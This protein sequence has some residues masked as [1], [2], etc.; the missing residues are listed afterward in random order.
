MA[1]DK[2]I[3]C[4]LQLFRQYGYEGTTLSKIAEAT[5]LG[6]ASLYHHFPGGKDEMV[7]AVLD[8]LEGWLQEH[9][10][11]ELRSQGDALT[12]LQ[13]MSASMSFLYEQGRQPCLFAILL[14]G[15]AKDIFQDRVRAILN[16]WIKEMA[17]VLVEAGLD[18]TE[19]REKAEDAAIA[20]QG[21]LILAQGLDDLTIFHR[22]LERLPQQMCPVV[23]M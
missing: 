14:M 12:R 3:A 23:T 16:I 13:R 9:I 6:K 18:P 15:S 20:I 7:S 4:L 22:T 2:Y 5:G 17:Q 11:G 8:S 1:K 10:I 21:A 19:A